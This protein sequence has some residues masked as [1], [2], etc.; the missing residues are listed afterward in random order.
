MAVVVERYGGNRLVARAVLEIISTAAEVVV[1]VAVA[2]QPTRQGAL[3]GIAGMWYT[4]HRAELELYLRQVAAVAARLRF[5]EPVAL[6]APE[7]D[8]GRLA[9]AAVRGVVS[10]SLSPPAQ[11]ERRVLRCLETP[12]SL[13]LLLA[14]DWAPL[15]NHS[16][17]GANMS[18]TYSYEIVSVDVSARC[19]EIVYR[20]DGR[21]TMHIGARLP[22]EGESLET[23]VQ[24][25]SPVR[26][27]EEQELAVVPVTIGASGVVTPPQP[28][29]LEPTA[30]PANQPTQTGAQEL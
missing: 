17:Q 26:Y 7:G 27:W 14:Q 19:M 20:A 9:Q 10:S 3:E 16:Q 22:Y 24:I 15:H 2:P 13:G 23:V 6:A 1:G 5:M 28:A 4:E 8:G 21:Q 29:A 18:I 11:V 30:V 12:T 25:F